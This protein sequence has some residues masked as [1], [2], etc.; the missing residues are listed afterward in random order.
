MHALA[1][2]LVPQMESFGG[3]GCFTSDFLELAHQTGMI[4]DKRIRY[5]FDPATLANRDSM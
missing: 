2:N 1:D 3:I 5:I 4:D